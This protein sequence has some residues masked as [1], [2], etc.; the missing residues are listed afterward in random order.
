MAGLIGLARRGRFREGGRVL[1]IHTG[2]IPGIFAY[3]VTFTRLSDAEAI[4]GV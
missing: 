4:A 1:W 3:P 2:G